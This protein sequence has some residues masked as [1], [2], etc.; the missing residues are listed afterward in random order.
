MAEPSLRGRRILVVEDEYMLADE[1]RTELSDA[2]AQ[3]LGPVGSL[4]DAIALIEAEPHIDGAV[5]DVNLHGEQ[6]YPAADLLVGRGIP[7]VFA[8]GYDA[9][10]MPDRFAH[11]VRC[12]KPVSMAKIAWGIGLASPETGPHH[13]SQ[14]CP[15][16]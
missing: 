16:L 5:L 3:V 7:F 8:T 11:V 12:E 10:A 15:R 14:D 1:L 6:A 2:G 9:A 4:G 13:R